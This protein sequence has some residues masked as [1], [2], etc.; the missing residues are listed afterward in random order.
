MRRL[1]WRAMRVPYE[2]SA[3]GRLGIFVER[4]GEMYS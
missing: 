3:L 1:R 4:G 2:C